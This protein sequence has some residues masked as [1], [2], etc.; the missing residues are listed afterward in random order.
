MIIANNISKS[1]PEKELFHDLSFILHRKDRMGV[2]GPNGCGKSTLLD[3]IAGK[4]QPDS[5]SIQSIGETM[6]S[7]PQ[8][9]EVPSTTTLE[10]Y[11]DVMEYPEVWRYLSELGLID[12][13]L[14]VPVM[15][16][17]G[18]QKT[19]LLLVKAFSRPATT[20]LLDEPTN[21]IDQETREWLLDALR[22]FNGIV[23]LISHDRA[24]LNTCVTHILEIDPANG[25]AVVYAGN[26]EAY[27]VQ[28]KQ[29]VEAE[30]EKYI[31]QQ[32]RKK[33]MVEWITLKRQQASVYTDP[34]LGKQLRQMER[35]LGREILQKEIGQPQVNEL[36]RPAEFAGKTHAG[37]LMVRLQDVQKVFGEQ[38]V[39]HNATLEIRGKTHVQVVG[40]NGSGKSTLL[41]LI[42][43]ELTPSSGKIEIGPNIQIGYFSQQLET[44]DVA[45]TVLETF[46]HTPGVQPQKARA[47]LGQ[48]LFTGDMVNKRI[49]ELSFGERV[50]LQL[51][52]ILQQQHELLILDEPTN[53]L[54]IPSREVM[55]SALRDYQG[56]LIIVSHDTYF[57]ERVGIDEI[58][59][60]TDGA[61]R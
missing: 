11:I 22:S 44:L 14:E 9:L 48:F 37:K 7:I 42:T 58:V 15:S 26:Y 41:K 33:E 13:P 24:F 18:G 3:I 4:I 46:V 54:D 8:T 49:R 12:L 32:R 20:L 31:L 25:R 2:I 34:A 40:E 36:I 21:H 10:E 38:T 60:M 23:I 57:L 56:A 47:I 50:R 17:S 1:V 35:R 27:K 61:L 53:H 39:I 29:W 30:T 19:K 16:L 55:E 51:A 6:Q 43:G 59:E 28:K 45:K 52:Q 5:G